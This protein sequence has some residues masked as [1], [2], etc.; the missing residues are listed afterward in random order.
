[1][2]ASFPVPWTALNLYIASWYVM[3]D[4]SQRFIRLVADFQRTSTSPIPRKFVFP[5]GIKMTVYHINSSARVLSRNSACTIETTFCQLVESGE[6][7]HIAVTNHWQ[8]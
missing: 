8:R 5:F 1:M 6:S 2:R 7:S 3:D 4:V